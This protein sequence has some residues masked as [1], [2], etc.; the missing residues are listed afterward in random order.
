MT[1]LT[2]SSIPSRINTVERL[3]VWCAQV[4]QSSANGVTVNVVANA[5]QRPRAAANLAVL[6]DNEANWYLE[7]Y[8]PCEL[9]EL[10]NPAEKTWMSAQQITTAAAN[11]NFLSNG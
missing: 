11:T 10:N 3:A 9:N 2:L 1:A 7:L 6:A 4:L 5:G 8:I